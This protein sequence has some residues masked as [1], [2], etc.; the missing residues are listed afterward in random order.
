MFDYK[1]R[2]SKSFLYSK[3]M[4]RKKMKKSIYNNDHKNIKY[5]KINLIRQID[6]HIYMAPNIKSKKVIEEHKIR[7]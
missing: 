1:S 4:S 3:V 2:N 6:I 7:S 5:L